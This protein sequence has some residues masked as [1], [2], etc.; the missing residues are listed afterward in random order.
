MLK[1]KTLFLKPL[2]MGLKMT[3]IIAC[4]ISLISILPEKYLLLFLASIIVIFI[5]WL[6]GVISIVTQ[7][8]NFYDNF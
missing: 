5:V 2:I 4:I 1:I 8:E 7:D 6:L 3:L